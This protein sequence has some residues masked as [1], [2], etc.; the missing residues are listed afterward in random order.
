MEGGGPIGGSGVAEIPS[1]V[2]GAQAGPWPGGVL[3]RGGSVGKGGLC[4]GIVLKPAVLGV[5][6]NVCGTRLSFR[7]QSKYFELTGV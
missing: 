6:E 5:G 4:A 1:A 7:P 3:G 2:V